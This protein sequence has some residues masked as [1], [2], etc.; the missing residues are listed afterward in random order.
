[1]ILKILTVG[2]KTFEIDWF[3][4]FNILSKVK[5]MQS[6][7][8]NHVQSIIQNVRIKGD[9]HIAYNHVIHEHGSNARHLESNVEMEKSIRKPLRKANINYNLSG[10]DR[11]MTIHISTI[12]MCGVCYYLFNVMSYR[13]YLVSQSQR[14]SLRCFPFCFYRCC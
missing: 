1:M 12:A 5:K 8:P 11:K 10:T 7:K 2:I 3:F 6:K 13:G 14:Y 4:V 9:T